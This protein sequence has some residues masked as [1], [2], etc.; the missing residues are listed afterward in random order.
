MKKQLRL[1]AHFFCAFATAG[2]SAEL[3]PL[4][5]NNA[6]LQMRIADGLHSLNVG[7][8]FFN[9]VPQKYFP[10][11]SGRDYYAMLPAICK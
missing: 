11:K 2:S 10:L 4:F 3:N 1:F 8:M 7:L 9:P 6:V 5:Q